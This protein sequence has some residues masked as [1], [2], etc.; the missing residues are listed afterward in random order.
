MDKYQETFDTWNKIAHIYRDRFMDLDLYN[1]TYDCFC[2]L[3]PAKGAGILEIGCGPGN[4]TRY[5]LGKRP[6]FDMTGIDVAPDMLEL[7]RQHNPSARFLAMDCR[8][9]RQLDARYDGIVCG[10]CIPYIS[11]EDIT[12]LFRDCHELLSADGL[13]YLSFVEGDPEASGYQTGSSGLRL[14]F[15]YHTR[16][17]IMQELDRNNFVPVRQFDVPYP[18]SD[19]TY[20]THTVMIFRKIK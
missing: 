9:L 15:Y 16:D 11:Q 19:T 20:E 12:T 5:L 10:F 2:E 8:D 18:K 3:V 6:D 7:A 17:H 14:F 4:I 13:L 1:E